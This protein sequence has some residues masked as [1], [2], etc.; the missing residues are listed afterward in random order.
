MKIREFFWFIKNFKLNKDIVL[1]I[2]IISNDMNSK[3]P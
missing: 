1:I 3:T 2:K